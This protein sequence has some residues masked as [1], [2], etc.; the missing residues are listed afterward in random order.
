VLQITCYFN[1]GK[2][3]KARYATIW[4]IFNAEVCSCLIKNLRHEALPSFL[5]LIRVVIA[6][7]YLVRM[8]DVSERMLPAVFEESLQSRDQPSMKERAFC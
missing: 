7:D 6:Q 8:L 1:P 4:L 2:L 5:L 3:R